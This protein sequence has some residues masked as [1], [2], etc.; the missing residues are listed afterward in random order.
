[1]RQHGRSGRGVHPIV[2]VSY[3][4]RVVSGLLASLI[5]ASTI[6]DR[7]PW[8]IGGVIAVGVG[9]PHLFHMLA[10]RADDQKRAG[11]R[12]LIAD[13]LIV[14]ALVGLTSLSPLPAATLVIV[15]MGFEVMV[16]G[17]RFILLG[18]FAL[19]LGTALTLPVVGFNPRFDPSLLTTNLCLLFFAGAIWSTAVIVNQNTRD[20]V[21]TRR[22]LVERNARIEEQS[23]QLEL[24]I[25]ESIEINEVARTVNATLD[26]DRVLEMVLRSLSK[27]CSFDQV[28]TLVLDSE[29]GRL[30]LDRFLGPR[31]SSE[32]VA[33]LHGVTVPLAASK[34][35][36][37][38]TL[39]AGSPVCLADLDG[40]AS[41]DMAAIDRE[42]YRLN[43]IRSLLIC[44]LEVHEEV[45]GELF[46]G[47]VDEP[48]D[49]SDGDLLA[50]E[51]YATHVAT[52]ISNARLFGVV[53][54]ARAAAEGELEIARRIQR[55]FLPASMPTPD[56]WRLA[57]RLLPARQ[58]SG[59]FYD[60]FELVDGRIVVVV[61]DVC[62]KGVGA[63]LFMALCRSLLRAACDLHRG[64]DGLLA[65][66]ALQFANEYIATIH[67]RA[68]MFATVFFGVFDPETGDL[69][70]ANGGHEPPLV[71]ARGGS[72]TELEPTGPAVGMVAE[73]GYGARTVM[74][75]P[76]DTLLA[77]TD[78][79]IEARSS[80]GEL[81]A[82]QRLR[83]LL[84]TR[85]DS[86]EAILDG[87]EQAVQ[88]HEAG[89]DQSDDLTLLAVRRQGQP[90]ENDIEGEVR[91]A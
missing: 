28:G 5:T 57:A 76:G 40:D 16:G 22:E 10:T 60:A 17:L 75:A 90:H 78:G 71:L 26:L 80:T 34:S 53:E 61:A 58:V 36:F 64:S 79:V 33:R 1:M 29:R 23:R 49:L 46:L 85:F 59:D 18:G 84:Q 52:A 69:E 83:E 24:A 42:I 73:S 38:R 3:L 81:F 50:I 25:A 54:R 86:P 19:S 39:H 62:D 35:V 13:G 7:S 68:N 31:A 20:L 41:S 70:Y 77:F 37:V 44:P 87:I 12:A 65:A 2:G 63:A 51:R 48:L 55:E 14:G 72:V 91:R 66:S 30:R 8:L 43:P 9:W 56:G 89:T 6:L 45:V 21:S 88:R 4:P 47:C 82:E 15:I 67:E 74:L 11:M 32:L 27:I